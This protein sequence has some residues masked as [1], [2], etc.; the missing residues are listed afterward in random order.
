VVRVGTRVR[1][2]H[3]TT[4]TRT[5]IAGFV[6]KLNS[7]LSPYGSRLISVTR[8]A[9]AVPRTDSHSWRVH[10]HQH[11][12]ILGIVDPQGI[13]VEI[14]LFAIAVLIVAFRQASPRTLWSMHFV[15]TRGTA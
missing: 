12:R 8:S 3:R 7:S 1:S 5:S 10:D 2:C 15:G 9:L 6:R 11:R 4:D 14:E 13:G